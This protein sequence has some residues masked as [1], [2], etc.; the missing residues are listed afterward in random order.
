MKRL[1]K[2]NRGT[3]TVEFPIVSL[4]VFMFIFGLVQ[5][6]WVIWADNLLQISVDVAARCGGVGSSTSPCT[7]TAGTALQNMQ[8]AANMVFLPL[9]GAT[10]NNNSS[11]SEGSGLAGSYTVNIAFVVN[12]TLTA[13]SCYPAV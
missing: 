5:T 4:P 1:F 12:L 9:S 7:T 6:G 13:N 10:F 8:A 2:N 11:C 3:S